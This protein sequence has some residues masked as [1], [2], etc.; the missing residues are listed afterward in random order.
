MR[1]VP[2]G[3]W[4]LTGLVGAFYSVFALVR[5]WTAQVAAW[6]LVIFDQVVRSSSHFEAP[7]SMIKGVHA[8]Y[9]PDFN[10]LADHVSPILAAL[11]PLY[12]IHD[13]PETLLVAQALLF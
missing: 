7:T 1:R 9:G 11:A 10:I 2:T 5:L 8:G 4:S 12:G 3:V 6:D 13:G